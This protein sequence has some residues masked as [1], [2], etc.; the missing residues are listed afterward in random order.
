MPPPRYNRRVVRRIARFI[1][2]TVAVLSLALCVDGE[3]FDL[4]LCDLMMPDMTGMDLHRELARLVPEQASR[5]IFL[6]GGA[7]TAK[8]RRFLSE[9]PKEHIEKPFDP[10]NL[11]AIAQRYLAERS[12]L[13]S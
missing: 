7:F 11:R 13:R 6:T 12:E 1:L 8:A 5:M 4:I 3:K 9:T 2:N 10:A